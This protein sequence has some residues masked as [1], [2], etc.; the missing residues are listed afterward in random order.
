VPAT[1]RKAAREYEKR[2]YGGN[3]AGN[4]LENIL[5]EGEIKLARS[6]KNANLSALQETA[7]ES[8][9]ATPAE[10]ILRQQYNE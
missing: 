1:A 7:R 2:E 6:G 10:T 4:T 5:A 3:M 8:N 9:P